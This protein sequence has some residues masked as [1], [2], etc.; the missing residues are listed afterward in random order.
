MR[1]NFKK[2][3][4]GIILFAAAFSIGVFFERYANDKVEVETV[5]VDGDTDYIQAS[6]EEAI[7]ENTVKEVIDGKVNINA[8]DVQT[9]AIID[10]IGEKTAQRII[11]YRQ[12]NGGFASIENIMD[13]SGIGEKKFEDIKN[14]ICVSD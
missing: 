1:K 13:V 9:L 4:A 2:F 5:A 12:E 14:S 6:Q 7:E 10:G 3:A 11:E 8:A